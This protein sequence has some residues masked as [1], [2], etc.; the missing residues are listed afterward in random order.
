MATDPLMGDVAMRGTETFGDPDRFVVTMYYPGP[1]GKE[2]KM[3]ELIYVRASEDHS[4]D[5]HAGHDH[6]KGDHPKGD[7]PN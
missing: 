5:E 1:D 7:H 6:P 3:M 2:F 4:H